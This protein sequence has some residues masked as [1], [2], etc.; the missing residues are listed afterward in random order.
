MPFFNTNF[1]DMFIPGENF[2]MR[3]ELN[4]IEVFCCVYEERSF[5]RAA[6]RLRVSQPTISGHIKNLENH[7]GTKLLDRQPRLI[8]PTRAGELLYRHGRKILDEKEAAGKAL[9]RLLNK[10]EGDLT[11]AASTIPGEFLVPSIVASFHETYP[12][13]RVEVRISDS[14]HVCQEVIS[15]CAEIGFAGARPDAIGL[16]L[17]PFA[18]DQ[19]ALVLR[20]D[21]KWREITSISK[22][23]LLTVPF[24]A[25]E[26]GSGTRIA[27]EKKI[28]LSTDALNVVGSF[29]STNAVKNAVLAGVGASV[30]SLL[31]VRDELESGQLKVLQIDGVGQIHREFLAVLN[32]KLAASPVLD[33]FIEFALPGKYSSSEITAAS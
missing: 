13:V 5:S 24:V 32:T 12:L 29:N 4:L 9:S 15:G 7:V 22:D 14:A 6:D 25:R 19:L 8:T 20:N 33:A 17:R 23:T 1:G 30:L 31:A 26:P 10:I 28:G 27:F 21:E 2:S 18:T 3:L 16:D 11:V